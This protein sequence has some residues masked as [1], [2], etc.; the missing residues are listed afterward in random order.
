[1]FNNRKSWIEWN[2]ALYFPQPIYSIPVATA[3]SKHVPQPLIPSVHLEKSNVN[4][5]KN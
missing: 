4:K 2:G 1:M 3:Q 5:R